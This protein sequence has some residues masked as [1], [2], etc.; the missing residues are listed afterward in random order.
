MLDHNGSYSHRGAV[1]LRARRL[2]RQ[3]IGVSVC[4]VL[5]IVYQSNR[6]AQ[7]SAAAPDPMEVARQLELD[8]ASARTLDVAVAFV[9]PSGVQ[10]LY[11]HFEDLLARGLVHGE[12][13]GERQGKAGEHL[14]EQSHRG[15][16]RV[17]LDQGN[18][19]IGNAG[20]FRKFTLRK[21]VHLTQGAQTPA[22]ILLLL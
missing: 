4:A 3:I 5:L 8:L 20:P 13:V 18:H 9:M 1:E 15:A 19:G 11:P 17:A 21:P 7:A 22:Q 10:K 6:P 14:L 16:C 2:K 12:E